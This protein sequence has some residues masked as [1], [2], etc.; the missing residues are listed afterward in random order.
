MVSFF[1]LLRDLA[2]GVTQ[3]SSYKRFRCFLK[4]YSA[5]LAFSA[6]ILIFLTFSVTE[7]QAY[8]PNQF[9][10]A[11]ISDEMQAKTSVYLGKPQIVGQTVLTGETQAVIP[12]IVE[13]GDT[14]TSIA[15]RHNIS[16]G[17]L[18]DFNSLKV[19]QIEKIK[20][21][22]E[23]L[24]PDSDTNTS[25]AW[26]DELNRLKE[27]ERERARQAELSRLA[28]QRN[29]LA[30]LPQIARTIGEVT[31]VGV[32]RDLP[33][34]TAYAGQ[35]TNYVMYKVP[36]L[37]SYIMGNGGQYIA[38]ARRYGFGTGNQPVAGGLVVTTE[39]RVG[40]VAYV[41]AVG[42]NS[43]TIS[44]MNYVG[45]FVV[46]RRTIPVNSPVIRGYVYPWR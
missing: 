44:E 18:I 30:R 45:P 14:L 4:R 5:Q 31:I 13:S 29:R 23:I 16:V 36:I 21:G 40:H 35:C 9:N 1:S 15:A 41:E 46:S 19:N 20:P 25:L 24:I 28:Q 43:I 6:F 39:A 2:F 42:N 7:G 10:Q 26:L 37:R 17:T 22:D 32:F 38:S 27:K 3:R 33:R 8:D 12:Y 11:F 34:G